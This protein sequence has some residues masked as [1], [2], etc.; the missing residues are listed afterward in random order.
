MVEIEVLT[1][2]VGRVMSIEDITT[3]DPS[4]NYIVRYRGQI[5]GDSAE[6][7]DRLAAS[8]RTYQITPLFRND[9]DRHAVHLL[10]GVVQPKPSNPWV[11]LILFLITLVSMI[12]AGALYAYNGPDPQDAP[13]ICG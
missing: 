3:G 8:L 6:A 13:S 4:K 5:Q 2:I 9:A 10:E 1:Q 11:N 7:F 12:F